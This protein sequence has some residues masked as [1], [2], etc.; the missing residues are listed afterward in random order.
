[1]HRFLYT[2]LCLFLIPAFA[3]AAEL[4]F[5]GPSSVRAGDRFTVDLFLDTEQDALN[6]LEGTVRVSPNLSILEIR[7]SGSLVPLWV[8]PPEEKETGVITFAGVL[9]GGYQGAGSAG[10]S[11]RGNVLTLLLEAR[12]AGVAE[13]SLGA[14]TAAYVND[15][16][17]TRAALTAAALEFPIYAP[18]GPAQKEAM[19][20]DTTPPEPFVPLIV[21]GAPFGYA[22]SVL[23]FST[24][25]KDS[26][27]ARVDI[28]HSYNAYAVEGNLSWQEAQSPYVITKANEDTYT[29]VRAVDRAGNAR[30]VVVPPQRTSI[31]ALLYT[32][33]LIVLLLL[34]CGA[35]L[36]RYRRSRL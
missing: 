30:V 17:G 12:A 22:D 20:E 36:Y 15:G 23:I 5:E 28:A 6:A 32:W 19:P 26:G 31:I 14:D 33:W 9:P 29:F 24:H 25:D 11:G 27:I 10:S 2:L 18:L 8:V 13:L 35:T 34:F 1:M 21:S 4:Y 3:N 7:F 16:Q